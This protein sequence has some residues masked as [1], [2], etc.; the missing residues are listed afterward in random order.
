MAIKVECEALNITM[1]Q[2]SKLSD[3][4]HQIAAVSLYEGAKIVADAIA[5]ELDALITEPYH[6]ADTDEDKMRYPSPR[7]VNIVK[8]GYGITRF[9]G[10][11][12]E[13]RTSI[14]YANSGY[15]RLGWKDVPIPM[16]AASINSGTS[17][18]HKQP[19]FRRAVNRAKDSAQAAI[20]KKGEDMIEEIRKK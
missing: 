8:R 4:A 1:A 2:F 18:M 15:A 3:A 6:R 20:L 14:G 12:A 19:F 16:I 13:L 10:T 11:G 9:E 5:P 7:E 17:F